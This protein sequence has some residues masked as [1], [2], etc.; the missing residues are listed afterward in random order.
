M[1][2]PLVEMNAASAITDEGK[3]NA[4]A[5]I[6]ESASRFTAGFRQMKTAYAHRNRVVAGA[7]VL[8]LPRAKSPRFT[9]VA[10]DSIDR[11]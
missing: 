11:S 7:A 8:E 2:L 10:D 6:R 1:N 3:T 5:L 4:F 9:N